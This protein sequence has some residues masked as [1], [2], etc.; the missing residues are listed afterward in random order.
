MQLLYAM[1][2]V[3]V[4]NSSFSNLFFNINVIIS[5]VNYMYHEQ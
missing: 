4:V 1:D 5:L 3:H 2:A